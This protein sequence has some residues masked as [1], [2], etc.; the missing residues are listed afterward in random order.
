[1]ATQAEIEARQSVVRGWLESGMRTPSVATMI[2]TR[3]CVSRTTAYREIQEISKQIDLSD[4]GPAGNEA[5]ELDANS[6]LASLQYQFDV[7][8]S[9]GDTKAACQLIKSMDTVRRWSGRTAQSTQPT[10]HTYS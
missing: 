9:I 2:Q 4:D 8:S 1:M 7:A 5:P 3:F 10:Q 6:L